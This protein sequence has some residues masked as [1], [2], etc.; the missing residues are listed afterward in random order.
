VT[1]ALRIADDD[2]LAVAV[3]AALH[4]G[5]ADALG[6]LLAEH[7]GLVNARVVSGGD[8]RGERTLLHVLADHPGRRPNAAAI[9]ALLRT[10]GAD[11][12]APFI[13][14][15]AE[16][17]LH[18]AAS[19]DDV[20]LVDALL[21]AG[22]DIEARGAVIGGG[23]PIADA[24]AFR[25]WRAA[26]R[27]VRRGARTN[28]FQSAAMGLMDRLDEALAAPGPDRQALTEALWGACHG[29]RR[30]AAAALVA[31]GADVNWVGWDDLTPLDAAERAGATE[32]AAW[33]RERG[34]RSAGDPR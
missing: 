30:E 8:R 25:Q 33:L 13:G 32:L 19:N 7:A 28:L 4:A 22:A 5:D 27:L 31:L 21:D 16:T 26:D 29:G 23:T 12:D 9:V 2:P 1:V 14:A 24:T 18:W 20:D 6:R 10:A 3:T 17:A 15:H 11:V 34:A